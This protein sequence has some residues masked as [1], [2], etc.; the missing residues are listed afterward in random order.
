MIHNPLQVRAS[1][2][3]LKSKYSRLKSHLPVQSVTIYRRE[4]QSGCKAPHL[5]VE[6]HDIVTF[7]VASQLLLQ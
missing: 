5:N 7:S 6:I 3:L 1:Q 4:L 2:S